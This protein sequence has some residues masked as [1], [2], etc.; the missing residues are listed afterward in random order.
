M[1]NAVV[2]PADGA[3]AAY[4]LE[5]PSDGAAMLAVLQK[6][7]GGFIEY[8]PTEAPITV[9]CNEEGKIDGLPT[10]YRATHLFGGLLQAG[11][12]IAG[13]VII[14]GPVD[15]EGVE[16][17]L[18]EEEVEA[19]LAAAHQITDVDCRR[20]AKWND[21]R[22]RQALATTAA[23][24][25]ALALEEDALRDQG[26]QEIL[27]KDLSRKEQWHWLSFVSNEGENRF[28]GV[29]VVL[30]GGIGEATEKAWAMGIN[31]GGQ[32]A[33]F[34]LSEGQ[35]PDEQYRNRLLS[36]EELE[37]AGLI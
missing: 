35:V 21:L 13:N 23:E 3:G 7:V 9:F 1:K 28:L 37:E 17:S 8:V 34:T 26:A 6:V 25:A 5:V 2:I 4:H 12:I 36:S 10:N 14:L 32:V 18:E 29:C 15:D 19:L 30:A 31:P 27:D 11:D 22:R 20:W 16:M 24:R 33:C